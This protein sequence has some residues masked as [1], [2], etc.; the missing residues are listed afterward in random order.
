[1]AIGTSLSFYANGINIA[2]A[3]QS[4]GVNTTIEE[5]DATAIADSGYRAFEVG[6]KSANLQGAGVFKWD[7]TNL[8]EIHNV[9]SLAFDGQLEIIVTASLASLAVGGDAILLNC[10]E[11]EYAINAPL[12]ELITVNFNLR[13]NNAFSAGKWL[14]NAAVASTTT[15]GTS[16]DNTAAST[17]GGLFHVH[18]QDGTATDCDVK[19]QHSTDNSV[20]VDLAS[21][22]TFAATGASSATVAA[23][24]TVNR[25]IRAS[26]TTTGGS[27]TVQAAFARR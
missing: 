2:N 1:M 18:V 8:D 27:S 3:I 10:N 4:F 19:V 26:V 9:L 24:T 13:S 23:G 20:W 21:C 14:F 11:Q 7:Q 25:Y 15:N 5:L 22:N 16:V 12:G 6:F 17:N